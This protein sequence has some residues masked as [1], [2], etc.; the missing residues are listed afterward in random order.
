ML[1]RVRCSFLGSFNHFVI[2]GINH[3]PDIFEDPENFN[4]DRYMRSEYGTKPGIDEKDF[5]HTLIFGAGRVSYLVN[6]TSSSLMHVII[7]LQRIC[8]G[9]HLANNSIV[10]KFNHFVLTEISYD[11]STD[12]EYYELCLGFRLLARYQS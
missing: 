2:G 12:A 10:R 5:R 3:D 6:I 1:V 4:P 9:M 11:P 8:S 7:I